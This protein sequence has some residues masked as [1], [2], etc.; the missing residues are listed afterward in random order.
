MFL[1]ISRIIAAS[2]PFNFYETFLQAVFAGFALDQITQLEHLL[3][4]FL[5]TTGEY[6][7]LLGCRRAGA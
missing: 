6:I 1:S 2:E 7:V 4:D 5:Y 3:G